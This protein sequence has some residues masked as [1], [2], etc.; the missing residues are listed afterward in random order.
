ME[1]KGV[2]VKPLIS[3]VLSTEM[4]VHWRDTSARLST[5]GGG[6]GD[7]ARQGLWVLNAMRATARYKCQS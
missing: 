4:S 5:G 3:D 6:D 7:Y 2:L 1:V